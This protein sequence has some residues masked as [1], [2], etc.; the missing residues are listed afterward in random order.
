MLKK[1]KDNSLFP[2]ISC[3]LLAVS[4]FTLL[5]PGGSYSEAYNEYLAGPPNPSFDTAWD[6]S[7]ARGY[8]SYMTDH[9]WERDRLLKLKALFNAFSLKNENNG[10]SYGK[11]GYMFQKFYNFPPQV[12]IANLDAIDLFAYNSINNVSVMIAPSSSYPLGDNLPEGLPTV[13]Q[14]F[15][16]DEFNRYLSNTA[17]PIN[18]KDA[19]VAE[20][21]KPGS[22]IYYRTDHN[23]TT[24]GAWLGYSQFA[25]TKEFKKT[26]IYDDNERVRVGGF[27]GASYSRGKPL[28]AA[29]DTIEYF[30]MPGTVEADGVTHEGL[31]NY[32]AFG[33]SNKYTAF[34]HGAHPRAVIRGEHSSS[35][36]DSIVVI[37]DS[38]AYCFIPFLTQNYNEV[39]LIDPNFY[40]GSFDE[41][42]A[43]RYDDV[44]ILLGF[45]TICANSNIAKLSM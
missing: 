29:P 27:L 2:L 25:A 44:L 24:Y 40:I 36:L 35:K 4:F 8:D 11:E 39:T 23:W 21:I 26:F 13:D 38:L 12:L 33:G 19:L 6:G 18:V 42:R 34:L 31:Y 32:A 7:L 14:E 1:I 22:Y 41:I 43:N 3:I 30:E 15:Y 28:S 45:E 9:I 16:I 10:V 37:G 5:S 20:A 17:T